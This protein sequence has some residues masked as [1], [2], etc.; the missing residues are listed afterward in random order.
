MTKESKAL[1]L[2]DP[3]VREAI[4]R[5]IALSIPLFGPFL[6]LGKTLYDI[7]Q[8]AEAGPTENDTESES[9]RKTVVEIIRAGKDNDAS[10]IDFVLKESVGIKL[11]SK[12]E[13]LPLEFS[14]G[15]S[16]E[17]SVKVKYK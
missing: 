16:G 6:V 13:G 8:A 17:M 5:Q 1:D 11:G 2:S 9:Q 12:L 15:K 10:E 7:S 4:G 14:V 3:V